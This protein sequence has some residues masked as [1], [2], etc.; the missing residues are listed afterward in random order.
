MTSTVI[1]AVAPRPSPP[2]S[3]FSAD[4]AATDSRRDVLVTDL[5]RTFSNPDL[6]L[7][8][9]AL[10]TVALLREEGIVCVLATGRWLP[11]LPIDPLTNL[12][13]GFVLE[14]G[15][16]WGAHD[17]LACAAGA[18][19]VMDAASV[20]E[21][22]G[23]QVRRRTASFSVDRHWEKTL[24]DMG[25]CSVQPNRDSI[26]VLPL[27]I[28]KGTGV[29]AWLDYAGI[30]PRRIVAVGDGE[31]DVP[32]LLRADVRIAVGNAVP[33]L[34]DVAEWTTR[35]EC[36]KGFVEAVYAAFPEVFA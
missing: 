13:D 30:S 8:A 17:D 31:N 7:N 26:D 3:R 15:A 2:T 28:D 20:L 14:G 10:A 11:E 9:H 24:R 6:S 34:R 29:S 36:A 25:S 16:R 21:A 23:A 19:H 12:F 22:A 1:G 18:P 27:G 33:Q 32:L 4:S 5:D 35:G